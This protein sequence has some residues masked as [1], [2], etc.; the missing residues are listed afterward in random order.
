MAIP[1]K[2]SSQRLTTCGVL[3]DGKTV[4]L[5]LVDQHGGPVSLQLPFEQA[6]AVIMTLPHLLTRAIRARTGSAEARYVFPLGKWL[7]EATKNQAC[8]QGCL[9][10]TLKTTDGFEVS[11]AIPFDTCQALG[12]TLKN[13]A[14]QAI[15]SV[16]FDDGLRDPGRNCLN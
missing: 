15:E 11:F 1:A 13:E 2:I 14:D 8:L 9:M 12:W 6:E 7:I 16:A 4:R 5:D 3:E 10:V